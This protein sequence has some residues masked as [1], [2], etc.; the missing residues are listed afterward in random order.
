MTDFSIGSL[1]NPDITYAFQLEGI[2]K[3]SELIDAS[4]RGVDYLRGIKGLTEDAVR[5]VSRVVGMYTQEKI[6]CP[7]CSTDYIRK[8]RVHVWGMDIVIGECL[9]CHFSWNEPTP[10]LSNSIIRRKKIQKKHRNKK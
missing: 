6:L 5:E 7:I 9:S 4:K 2:T 8:T 3:L 10:K 1:F